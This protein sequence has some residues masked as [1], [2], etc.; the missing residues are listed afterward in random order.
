MLSHSTAGFR[1]KERI[2]RKHSQHQPI[3]APIGEKRWILDLPIVDH[4]LRLVLAGDHSSVVG[5]VITCVIVSTCLRWHHGVTILVSVHLPTLSGARVPA[6]SVLAQVQ[7]H[8]QELPD[9]DII[10]GAI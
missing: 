4:G 9:I 3:A 8:C 5:V 7:L 2:E 1:R 6:Q 10:K